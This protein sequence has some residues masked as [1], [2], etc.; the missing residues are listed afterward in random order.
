[1]VKNKYKKTISII[2]KIIS[3]TEKKINYISQSFS[4]LSSLAILND[5]FLETGAL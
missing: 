3:K 5:F 1:M 2:N 4:L